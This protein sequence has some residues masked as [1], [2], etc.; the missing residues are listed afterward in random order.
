MALPYGYNTRG[1][2]PQWCY[3]HI[4]DV[5]STL[6]NVFGV[7][8]FMG[9]EEFFI[10]Y[11]EL[12]P[13]ALEVLHLPT[14]VIRCTGFTPGNSLRQSPSETFYFPGEIAHSGSGTATAALTGKHKGNNR[15]RL[16]ITE[17]GT[18]GM[19]GGYEL[20]KT[21]WTGSAWGTETSVASGAVP[22]DG[23]IFVGNG[24]ILCL[25]TGKTVVLGDTYSWE[26]QAYK[27]SS[28]LGRN[29]TARFTVDLYLWKPMEIIF[30]PHNLLNQALLLFNYRS[31]FVESFAGHGVEIEEA[32]TNVRPHNERIEIVSVDEKGNPQSS[33]RPVFMLSLDLEYKG[34]DSGKEPVCFTADVQP[35][36]VPDIEEVKIPE[37]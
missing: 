19:D 10:G 2:T 37:D 36:V 28:I 18:V 24:Q 21:E 22:V 26:T 9:R 14:A 3:S 33:T 30:S 13:R 34:P 31:W 11:E 7:E 32:L 20:F 29:V 27:V 16:V 12:D 4:K 8:H 17:S 1:F 23:R 35:L 25:E 6:K 15:F 5:I